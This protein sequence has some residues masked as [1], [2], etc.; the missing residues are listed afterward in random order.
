MRVI[1]IPSEP[2]VENCR[3][4]HNAQVEL[5]ENIFCHHETFLYCIGN[6]LCIIAELC[7]RPLKA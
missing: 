7:Y 2:N 1:G 6:E 3:G 5:P 4:K